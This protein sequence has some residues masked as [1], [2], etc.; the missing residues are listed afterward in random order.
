MTFVAV[1]FNL[2]LTP[3][4]QLIPHGL[5]ARILGF[6]P[7]GPGSIPGVGE[8]FLFFALN[9]PIFWAGCF[10]EHNSGKGFQ[11]HLL[12]WQ[13]LE[14]LKKQQMWNA[15]KWNRW[16][17]HFIWYLSTSPVELCK[18]AGDGSGIIEEFYRV[19]HMYLNDFFKM[20]VALKW[21][22]PRLQ[23]FLCFLSMI[24]ANFSETLVTIASIFLCPWP[25]LN[26]GI[27][28]HT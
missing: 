10:C 11:Y 19:T 13:S 17:R 3:F 5:M 2:R 6:H 27:G 25:F 20:G 24:M 7:R 1:L 9:V 12:H 4:L 15:V 28:V 14:K 8:H 18:G 21:G 23:N 16:S 22:K 26:K